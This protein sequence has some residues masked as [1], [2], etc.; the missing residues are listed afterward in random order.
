[1]MV[2]CEWVEMALHRRANGLQVTI[3]AFPT[4]RHPLHAPTNVDRLY[5][6]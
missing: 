5:L 6:D 1:M 4:L 2:A 3:T